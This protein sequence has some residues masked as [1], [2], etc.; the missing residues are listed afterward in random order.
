MPGGS[1]DIKIGSKW[2]FETIFLVSEREFDEEPEANKG[3]V[4]VLEAELA[5]K[6][7]R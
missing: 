4:G 3:L 1:I 5:P 2:N 6:L 7:E